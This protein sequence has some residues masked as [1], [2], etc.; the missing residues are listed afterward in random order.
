[1][2]S[3]LTALWEVTSFTTRHLLLPV[4]L[5]D[6]IAFAIFRLIPAAKPKR[7]K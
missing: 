2:E 3:S 5:F 1:M 6:L 4:L 7:N